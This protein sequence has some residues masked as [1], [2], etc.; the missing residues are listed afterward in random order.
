VAASFVSLF[1][2]EFPDVEKLLKSKGV[3]TATAYA[4]VRTKEVDLFFN[5]DKKISVEDFKELLYTGQRTR[6]TLEGSKTP[7]SAESSPAPADISFFFNKLADAL[8]FST[9]KYKKFK[10]DRGQYWLTMMNVDKAMATIK[11]PVSKDLGSTAIPWPKKIISSEYATWELESNEASSAKYSGTVIIPGKGTGDATVSVTQ[12]AFEAGKTD[13]SVK[14]IKIKKFWTLCDDEVSCA[15]FIKKIPGAE[16]YVSP[17][18]GRIRT[19]IRTAANEAGSTST[20]QYQITIPKVLALEPPAL[21]LDKCVD[22]DEGVVIFG[23]T[24][25]VGACNQTRADQLLAEFEECSPQSEVSDLPRAVGND[26]KEGTFDDFAVHHDMKVWANKKGFGWKGNRLRESHPVRQVWRETSLFSDQSGDPISAWHIK[27]WIPATALEPYDPKKHGSICNDGSVLG[28]GKPVAQ[29]K[30]KGSS[31]A[32]RQKK[33]AKPKKKEPE[34][35]QP[36]SEQAI[37]LYHLKELSQR[38]KEVRESL[39]NNKL[40]GSMS[41]YNRI[42]T[43]D[44]KEPSHKNAAPIMNLVTSPRNMGF[45]F[46]EIRPVHLSALIPR[47]RVFKPVGTGT[48][49]IKYVEYEFEEYPEFA[50]MPELLRSSLGT[51][52]GVGIRQFQW[53]QSGQNATLFAA[54]RFIPATLELRAQSVDELLRERVNSKGEKYSFSDMFY[55]R[56]TRQQLNNAAADGKVVASPGS[57]QS[58]VVIEYAVDR[59]NLVWFYDSDLASRIEE[60]KLSLHMM[61]TTHTID[62]NDDGSLGITLNFM[63][64]FDEKLS[65]PRDSNILANETAHQLVTAKVNALDQRKKDKA[66]LA[67]REIEKSWID[68]PNNAILNDADRE[69]IQGGESYEKLGKEIQELNDKIKPGMSDEEFQQFMTAKL[70]K[71]ELYSRLTKKLLMGD[72][73][74]SISVDP[75]NV[76]KAQKIIPEIVDKQNGKIL[77]YNEAFNPAAWEPMVSPFY[78]KGSYKIP[79]LYYGDIL[80]A[81]LDGLA[82]GKPENSVRTILGPILFE[83]AESASSEESGISL[84]KDTGKIPLRDH[85]K[86]SI[87]PEEVSVEEYDRLLQERMGTSDAEYEQA[88]AAAYADKPPT[89]EEIDADRLVTEYWNGPATPK[90]AADGVIA[91]FQSQFAEGRDIG[92][93]SGPQDAANATT[94]AFQSQFAQTRD[95]GMEP[96]PSPSTPDLDECGKPKRKFYAV[97]IADIPISFRL[98]QRWWSEK[99]SQKNLYTYPLKNFISD[100][101]NSLVL[102]AL[103]SQDNEML[104]P[105]QNKELIMT[106]FNGVAKPTEPDAFR[107]VDDA[108]AA[109]ISTEKGAPT[110]PLVQPPSEGGLLYIEDLLSKKPGQSEAALPLAVDANTPLDPTREMEDYLMIYSR[111]YDNTR[112]YQGKNKQYLRDVSNGIYHIHSGREVGIVKEIS[113]NVVSWDKFESMHMVAA[114]QNVKGDITPRKRLYNATVTLFG[115][116]FFQPG[117]RVYINPAAHGSLENLQELGMVGYYNVVSVSSQITPGGYTTT[118]ECAFAEPGICGE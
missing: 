4:T 48:G 105:I 53:Q 72:N 109:S 59:S 42:S 47:I 1:S 35:K 43:L 11:E 86:T 49:E 106:T 76:K 31:T 93:G 37:L 111:E 39:A 103:Q 91:A 114:M 117:H 41:K 27:Y 3:K 18:L 75:C 82:V 97:N 38:N 116:P 118:L 15:T 65:D 55:P 5:F 46:D 98:F 81:V 107:F 60:M 26:L 12:T 84:Q 10:G 108:S 20:W 45:L 96:P 68:D 8:N 32:K 61:V 110:P 25:T 88:L 73:F 64:R 9:V 33:K 57:L 102:A 13:F 66:E 2:D 85:Y 62:M 115:A 40:W 71:Q 87:C 52:T 112:I 80:N 29:A 83:D 77:T 54:Q 51:S 63:A 36:M 100:S 16:A 104:L 99:I 113:M 58:K 23:D 34:I 28:P 24:P 30:K 90:N 50:T 92:M 70:S 17:E 19:A 21:N 101:L 79:F 14:V 67:S 69:T 44:I 22:R 7:S 95:I 6:L 94:V 74:C 56:T 78:R 89:Q